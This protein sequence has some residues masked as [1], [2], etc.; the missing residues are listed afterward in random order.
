MSVLQCHVDC[1]LVI[2]S[3]LGRRWTVA[4]VSGCGRQARQLWPFCRCLQTFLPSSATEGK[5]SS[6]ALWK[7]L[8]VW[9]G[10][11]GSDLNFCLWLAKHLHKAKGEA[12]VSSLHA[13]H[14]HGSLL[15]MAEEVPEARGGWLELPLPS[16]MASFE[17]CL[18]GVSSRRS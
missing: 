12:E 1:F 7:G 17:F 13:M 18:Y 15:S 2:Y 14:V 11:T 9:P 4:H 16:L 10:C 8:Y 3:C 6:G 5:R